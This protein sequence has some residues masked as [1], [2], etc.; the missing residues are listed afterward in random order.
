MDKSLSAKAGDTALIPCP[1][2]PTCHRPARVHMPHLLSLHSATMK[3][4]LLEPVLCNK[5]SHR[6]EKS[7]PKRSNPHSLQLEKAC[8]QH[9]RPSAAKTKQTIWG[10]KMKIQG[11]LRVTL[12]LNLVLADPE[13][14]FK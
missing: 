10:E 5:R 11:W 9:R 12:S 3:L 1:G 4:Q 8:T 14:S 7:A 13:K 2:D 6:N